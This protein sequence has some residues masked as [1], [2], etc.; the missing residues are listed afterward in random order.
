MNDAE[1]IERAKTRLAVLCPIGTK[2]YVIRTDEGRRTGESCYYAVLCVTDTET[3]LQNISGAVA[4]L[5][6]RKWANV[7]WPNASAVMA[8]NPNDMIEELGVALHG[9][10]ESLIRVRL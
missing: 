3:G 6:G 10:H 1:R 5:L 9:C 4:R 2:L 8:R 7:I